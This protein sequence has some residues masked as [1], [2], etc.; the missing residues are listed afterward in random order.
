MYRKIIAFFCVFSLLF[1]F[2]AAEEEEVHFGED[3]VDI[4][5]LLNIVQEETVKDKKDSDGA[6]IMT[7][8]CTGDFT[9]GDSHHKKKAFNTELVKTHDGDIN[10]VM[11]NVRDCLESC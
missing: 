6:Y 4:T 1:S 10:F 3:D 11:Q 9:I 2:A 7:V 5:E 8:T